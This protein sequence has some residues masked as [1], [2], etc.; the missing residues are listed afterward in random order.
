MSGLPSLRGPAPCHADPKSKTPEII[1]HAAAALQIARRAPIFAV[2]LALQVSRM[3]AYALCALSP[4]PEG[5]SAA[6]A[7]RHTL[8]LA[9]HAELWGYKRYWLAEHHNMSG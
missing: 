8:D 5:A 9:R 1:R 4:T 7:F 2:P 6:D 3:I